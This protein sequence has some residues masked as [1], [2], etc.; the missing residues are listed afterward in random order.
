MSPR[1]SLRRALLL[2]LA[3][4][5]ALVGCSSNQSSGTDTQ[6]AGSGVGGTMAGTPTN[7]GGGAANSGGSGV[8]SPQAGTNAG[9]ST[10]ASGGGQSATGGVS[11]QAGSAGH[12]SS[13]S[14]ASG[15]GGRS[16]TGGANS[17]GAPGSA[18]SAS[19]GGSS[20][21]Q[22]NITIWIAGDSTVANG[23]P[24]PIGWGGQFKALFNAKVA[25]TNSAVGGRSVR[26]WLYDV[27]DTKDSAGECNLGKDAQG[28]PTVQARWT[29]MLNGMKSG[30]YLFI[31]F[32][33]NDGDS[34]C[35][36]HVGA[37][38][39]KTSYGML[40]QAAKDHGAQPVFIT[41]VSQIA[42]SGS[43]VSKGT[44]EPYVTATK[45][46]G[47]QFGVPVID[48][49]LLSTTLYQSLGFC[50]I[51]GGSDVSASTTGAVGTFFCDDH[52]HFDTS[53]AVQI[54]GLV[55]QAVRDQKLGL[56]A[57]LK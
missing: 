11:A 13:S 1:L 40:A 45:E 39:F 55:A 5:L 7:G 30:D 25:V 18:G 16:A 36:R 37:N 12:S 38:A 8:V 9:G 56:A 24:C 32:G 28:N 15:S 50:P 4:S 44:R 10:S 29:A 49:N 2:G 35:P 52:T 14:G 51:P 26:T 48:L 6:A 41:P 53:G 21:T 31:Q 34:A 42:C 43:T 17:G 27:Q 23:G 57:Y 33:I 20:G 19:G 22:P 47:T 54:A 46:A 3:S